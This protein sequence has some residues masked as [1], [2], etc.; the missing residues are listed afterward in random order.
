[1]KK[2]ACVLA[3]VLLSANV[4]AA[5]LAGV[6]MADTVQLDGQQLVFNGAGLRTK[7]FF[8]IYVAALYLTQKQTDGAAVMADEH[9]HR[10]ALHIK[11]ELGSEKLYNAFNDAIVSNQSPAQLAA[12]DSQLKQMRQI[13]DTVHEVKPGDVIDLDYLPATG[14]QISVNGKAYG[15]IAGAAF[16]RAMLQIWLGDKPVQNDLKK[17]LLGG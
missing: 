2:F 7:F 5:E 12:L 4:A 16:N 3:G 17:G 9:V 11:H 8:K 15:T 10:L 6:K 13:F 14:T 1:M